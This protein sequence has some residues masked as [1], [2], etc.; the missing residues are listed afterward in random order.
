MKINKTQTLI[1]CTT[2]CISLLTACSSNKD[3][4]KDKVDWKTYT[5][6]EY[7]YS[8]QL[9]S[10]WTID[11]G[12]SHRGETGGSTYFKDSTFK[13]IFLIGCSLSKVSETWNEVSHFNALPTKWISVAGEEAI[14]ILPLLLTT[15][16]KGFPL[17]TSEYAKEINID[18]I[19]KNHTREIS[20]KFRT[21]INN[22]EEEVQK[23]NQLL[24]SF[25]FTN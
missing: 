9:P 15:N 5:D 7:G 16:G 1:Y 23:F 19:N 2:V 20:L 4:T 10:T 22:Y 21:S 12:E 24:S 17:D 11:K 3:I 13:T 6:S 8:F 14:E 25:K 18:F